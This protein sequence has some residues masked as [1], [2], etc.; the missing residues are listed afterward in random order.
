MNIVGQVEIDPWCRSILASHWPDVPLHDD[1]YT[2]PEWWTFRPRP[3]V[4]LVSGGIPCQPHSTAGRRLGIADSRWLWPPVAEIIRTVAPPFVLIENVPRLLRSGLAD[5][6]HDLAGLGFDAWWD[7]VPAAALGAPHLRWRLFLVAAHPGRCGPSFQPWRGRGQ[8]WESE[9]VTGWDGSV[10]SLAR[11]GRRGSAVRGSDSGTHPGSG[12]WGAES[13]V[14]RVADG[15]PGRV[16]RLRALGNAVVPQVAEYIG[17]H[18][19]GQLKLG[20]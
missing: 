2:T 20:E 19:L 9:A 18:L 16:D 17:R 11:G 13:G 10:W 3:P 15:V 8:D 6:L 1:V 5:I 12:M 4:H 14:C 7:R